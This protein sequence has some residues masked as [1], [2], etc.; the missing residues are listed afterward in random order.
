MQFFERDNMNTTEFRAEVTKIMPGYAWTVKRPYDKD[1][2]LM[3]ATG[4]QSAGF[5]RMSTLL[6]ER[7]VD[8]DKTVTYKVYISG[9]GTRSN[10]VTWDKGRTLARALRSLQEQCSA[11]MRMY[12]AC[13]GAMLLGRHP[14]S[15][16][17][18]VEFA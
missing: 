9:Y 6:V 15:S 7:R 2:S 5:N 13:V 1:C 3:S 11:S 18:D 12:N 4:I 14:T 17:V 10:W 16:E 8:D